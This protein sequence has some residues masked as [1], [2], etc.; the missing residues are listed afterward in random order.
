MAQSVD[1]HVI[2]SEQKDT[3]LGEETFIQGCVKAEGPFG[4]NAQVSG[5]LVHMPRTQ[6]A[7]VPL[8]VGP[9]ARIIGTI[10][11]KRVVIHGRVEGEIYASEHV[12]ISNYGHVTGKVFCK[13]LQLDYGGVLNGESTTHMKNLDELIEKKLQKILK[14]KK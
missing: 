13:G 12:R 14:I 3:Y 10:I 7:D 9:K 6:S 4:C 2:T 11:A 5:A 1:S 8:W